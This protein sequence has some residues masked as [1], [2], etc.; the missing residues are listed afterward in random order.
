[1]KPCYRKSKNQLQQINGTR[2]TGTRSRTVTNQWYQ[3]NRNQIKNWTK[4]MVPGEQEPDQELILQKKDKE[5]SIK[6]SNNPMINNKQYTINYKGY[7]LKQ[8]QRKLCFCFLTLLIHPFLLL[9]YLTTKPL[10]DR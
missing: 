3:E 1:M 10:I 7:I 6:Y 9:S 4:S 8:I 5:L 2:R